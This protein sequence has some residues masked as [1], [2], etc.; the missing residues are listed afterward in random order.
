MTEIEELKSTIEIL[1]RRVQALEDFVDIS[2][3][4][5]QYGPDVDYGSAEAAA[6]LWLED[7][8][9]DA[10]NAITMTG[11][12][13][14]RRM[15][16]G[17]GHQKGLENGCGHV[18]TTPHIVVN[19]DEAVGRSYA[20]KLYW[21]ETTQRFWIGRLSANRWRWKRTAE[22][23]KVAERVNANLDGTALHRE[24]FKPLD[25]EK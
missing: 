25:I 16:N 2:Q 19:G 22:G 20:L 4:V 23:W 8:V 5:A 7:G 18:L 14:I 17:E 9:Y 11:R 21:D 10:V 12:D 6:Q 24:L 15:V 13:A 3:N 1:K